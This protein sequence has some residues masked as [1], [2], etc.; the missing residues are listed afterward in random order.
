[1]DN[2]PTKQAFVQL[3][4][5]WQ[6]ADRL[7]NQYAKS[8]DLSVTTILVFQ[9]LH[10]SNKMLTQTEISEKLELPKQ[11]VHG[12]IKTL[13]EQGYVKLEETKDR[14]NKCII[15]TDDGKAY[16]AS[17]IKPLDDAESA[18]WDVFSADEV[19]N[20]ANTIK[21]YAEFVEDFLLKTKT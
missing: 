15:I 20:A 1:M 9:I 18:A 13:W 12:V 17:I 10:E 6:K 8:V 4:E 21:K 3:K 5:A 19:L 16:I 2:I 11:Y 7:Y 14:R